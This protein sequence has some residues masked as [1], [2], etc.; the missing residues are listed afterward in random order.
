M[1]CPFVS[2]LSS[3]LSSTVMAGENRQSERAR[4]SF[5]CATACEGYVCDVV[6]RPRCTAL[7][8]RKPHL[9]SCHPRRIHTTRGLGGGGGGFHTPLYT[10]YK[11]VLGLHCMMWNASRMLPPPP[12]QGGFRNLSP[13]VQF[14]AGIC[15]NKLPPARSDDRDESSAESVGYIF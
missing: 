1:F 5:S 12:R 2:N 7:R 14:L 4:D 6:L 11:R 3:R 13:S 10:N 9:R 15:D 8:A